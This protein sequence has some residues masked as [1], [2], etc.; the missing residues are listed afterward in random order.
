MKIWVD[1]DSCP[2]IAKEILYRAAQR[3]GVALILVAN[4]PL[5][6]PRSPHIRSMVVAQGFDVADSAIIDAAEPGDLAITADIPMAAALL[7]KG[8][9]VID[10]RGGRFT[11]A[12]IGI[13]LAMRD[14]KSELRDSGVHTGGPPA[15][16]QR[17]RQQ[18][19]NQLDR[20]L[21]QVR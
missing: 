16:S 20:L 4:R 8:V 13:Q 1:A 15:Y 12:S 9:D 3:T 14:I 21:A 11:D 2:K 17:D 18:F 7:D 10:T 6:I 19:A 5:T